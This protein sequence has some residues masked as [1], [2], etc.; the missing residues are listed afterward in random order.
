MGGKTMSSLALQISNNNDD[1]QGIGSYQLSHQYVG[2]WDS[3]NQETGYIFKPSVGQGA[4]FSDLHL[5]L[6]SF[7]NQSD[8]VV[9]RIYGVLPAYA[10]AALP[11]DAT[12]FEALTLT[13]AY[14]DWEPDAWSTGEFYPSPDISAI[15]N[16]VLAD[17]NWKP[18]NRLMLVVKNNGGPDNTQRRIYDYDNEAA[19]AAKLTGTY[20]GGAAQT[21]QTF[22]PFAMFMNASY[23]SSPATIVA[24][25]VAHNINTISLNNTSA[26]GAN[27]ADL[28]DAAEAEGIKVVMSFEGDLWDS[29]YDIGPYTVTQAHVIAEPLIDILSAESSIFAVVLDDEPSL[30]RAEQVRAMRIAFNQYAP[31]WLAFPGLIGDVDP[32]AN[33]INGNILV[34]HT[35]PCE[36]GNSPGD[37]SPGGTDIVTY[38]RNTVDDLDPSAPYWAMMQGHDVGDGSESWHLRLPTV[39][40]IRMQFWLALEEGAKGFCFFI[41]DWEGGNTSNGLKYETDLFNEV[42]NLG[43]LIPSLKALLLAWSKTT[44]QVTVDGSNNASTFVN[45]STYYAV[46]VNRSVN[47]A[48]LTL[49]GTEPLTWFEDVANGHQYNTGQA[50]S[51]TGGEGKIFKLLAS[52]TAAVTRFSTSRWAL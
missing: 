17:A 19:N 7:G 23:L 14:V 24:D 27:V 5:Q 6:C 39:A 36:T 20:T 3:V 46:A 10:E 11:A 44:D 34:L 41:Y 40:E 9:L 8:A 16:E 50:I 29:Y 48:D 37:L 45:D 12:E 26:E 42:A 52:P 38:I 1:Y 32:T 51:F 31:T 15:G 28:L 18:N 30:A 13:T 2:K 47:A 4:T 22:V 25:L 33:F 21:S 43:D 49:T 35:Y